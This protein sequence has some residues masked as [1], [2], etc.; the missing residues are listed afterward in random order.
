MLRRLRAG[1]AGAVGD[2][3]GAVGAGARLASCDR[4][5]RHGVE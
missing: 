1:V 4:R 3:G 2:G 5:D